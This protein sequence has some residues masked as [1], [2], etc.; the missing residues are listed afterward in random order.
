MKDLLL[1]KK[2]MQLLKTHV[3]AA[4]RLFCL[5][6]KYIAS[7]LDFAKSYDSTVRGGQ[8]YVKWCQQNSNNLLSQFCLPIKI[9]KTPQY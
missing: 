7:C 4:P 1:L 5:Y 3:N 2:Y 8:I 9:I 6:V